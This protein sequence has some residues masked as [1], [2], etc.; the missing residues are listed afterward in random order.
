MDANIIV[1]ADVVEPENDSVE[2]SDSRSRPTACE[3]K[4][5][6][7]AR[8]VREAKLEVRRGPRPNHQRVLRAY[9]AMTPEQKLNLVFDLSEQVLELMKVGLRLRFPDLDESSL[10]QAYLRM[11]ARCHKRRY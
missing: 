8:T 7:E 9:R 4:T 6:C 3:T 5:A 10:N 11:R 2:F 1:P